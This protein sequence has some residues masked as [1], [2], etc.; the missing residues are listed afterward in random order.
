MRIWHRVLQAILQ[1]KSSR[2]NARNDTSLQLESLEIRSLLASHPLA[3]AP[4]VDYEVTDEWSTG[5]S[6]ALTLTNDES[7]SFS[8]WQL[9]FD[10]N[11]QIDSL[12]N[13]EVTNLGGG[14]YAITPPDWDNTLDAGE[15]LAIGFS[16]SGSSG[17]SNITF[18]GTGDVAPEDPIA[19]PVTPPADQVDPPTDPVD[20]PVDETPV[21]PP[22][23]TNP[24]QLPI[25]TISDAQVAEGDSG[26]VLATFT[27]ALSKAST[28]TVSVDF[29]TMTNT[30]SSGTDFERTEGTITFAAG[31]TSTTIDVRVYGDLEVENDE[32]FE[33]MLTS[34]S[35]AIFETTPDAGTDPVITPVVPGE[36]LEV[37]TSGT[38]D[39][40][41]GTDS[42]RV[43]DLTSTGA[44]NVQL[45]VTSSGNLVVL[46][47]FNGNPIQ[48]HETLL[49]ELIANVSTDFL[50]T[51]LPDPGGRSKP[52]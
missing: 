11:G 52:E 46:G 29:H 49:A 19:P 17:I 6:A 30:A 9:E 48:Q 18:N 37:P 35:G 42:F 43:M 3:D 31:E 13:A 27:V 16:A 44:H 28:E 41:S 14:R 39:Y 22:I 12:W 36:P 5:H 8:N 40:L 50:E 4:D 34:P 26:F 33:V 7:T 47:P 1:G 2:S 21:T 24:V 45:M 32:H 20:S 51:R 38:F 23:D 25:L 10:Y 15:S